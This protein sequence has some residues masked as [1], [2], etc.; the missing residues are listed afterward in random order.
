MWMCG[1]YVQNK[2]SEGTGTPLSEKNKFPLAYIN[3]F[4]TSLLLQFLKLL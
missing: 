2:M 1:A 3:L 4:Q